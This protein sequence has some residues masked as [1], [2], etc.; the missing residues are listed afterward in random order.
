[1]SGREILF[2]L[3]DTTALSYDPHQW[4]IMKKE[5]VKKTG[6]VR[7]R[8]K[9]FVASNKGVLMRVIEENGVGPPENGQTHCAGLKI[10]PRHLQ[11][12]DFPA[13]WR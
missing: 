3:D 1:M 12:V 7:W 4:I 11:G 9:S 5:V 10:A 6:V 2:R 8:P 13:R